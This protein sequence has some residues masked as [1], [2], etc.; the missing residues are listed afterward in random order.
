VVVDYYVYVLTNGHG[1]LYVGM[2][3]DLHRRIEEHRRRAIP[4]FKRTN[5]V[6]RLVYHESTSNPAAAIARE[7]EIKGWRKA[8][9]V[10]LVSAANPGWRDLGDDL[11]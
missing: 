10:A 5:N 2:T 1:T 8:R 9:K 11:S 6:D 4:G 3:N 7:K